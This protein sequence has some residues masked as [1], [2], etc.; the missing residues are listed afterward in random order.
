MVTVGQGT[1]TVSTGHQKCGHC[2]TGNCD[3]V[4]RTSEVWSLWDREL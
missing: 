1:V 2:G 4:D 3:S